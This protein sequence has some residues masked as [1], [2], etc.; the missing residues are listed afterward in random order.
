[1]FGKKSD[2]DLKI[3]QPIIDQINENYNNLSNLSD[4]ELK[5]KFNLIKNNLQTSINDN[6]NKL[7]KEKISDNEIDDKLFNL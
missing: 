2:K 5:D 7:T 4:A 1:M 3:I 6:K